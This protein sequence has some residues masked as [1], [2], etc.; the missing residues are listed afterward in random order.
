MHAAANLFAWAAF[1]MDGGTSSRGRTSCRPFTTSAIRRL[2]SC[3]E[4]SSV[5]VLLYIVLADCEVAEIRLVRV[6]LGRAGHWGRAN[7]ATG[8]NL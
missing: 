3:V 4:A 1:V 8:G 6:A 5:C 7:L 2:Y